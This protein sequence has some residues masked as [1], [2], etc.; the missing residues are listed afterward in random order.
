VAAGRASGLNCSCVPE[1]SCLM[2]ATSKQGYRLW[3]LG[4]FDPLKI[5]RRVRVCFDP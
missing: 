5:C 2:R 3:G 1:K 4:S